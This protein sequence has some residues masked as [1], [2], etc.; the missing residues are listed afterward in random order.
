M[1][2]LTSIA[3]T[4]H[5]LNPWMGCFKVSDGCKHCYADDLT[6]GRMGLDVFGYDTSKRKRTSAQIWN[7]PYRWNRD[8]WA[9]KEPARVFCASLAD[10]FEDAPGPNRWRP[11]LFK[12]VRVT[13]WLDWQFLTKRPENFSRM[14][15]D[16]WGNGWCNVWLGTSIE[17]NRVI[18]RAEHLT[19]TPAGVHFISYEPAIGPLD[20]LSLDHIEWMIVGGESGPKYRPMDLDWAR[21]MRRRC[22]GTQTAFFFKQNSAFR[23]EMGIDALGEV[24]R[25]YPLSWHRPRVYY[26]DYSLPARERVRI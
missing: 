17:D 10:V 8:A 12:I 11:E 26:D 23:T 14:L 22:Y 21:D 1:G 15:P 18:E 25:E 2:D 3:W 19:A 20:E 4:D 9:A 24:I 5:T 13:P 7:R 16:D 6:S